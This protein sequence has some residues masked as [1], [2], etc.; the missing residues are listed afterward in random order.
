MDKVSKEQAT[1]E[2]TAWLDF[3]KVAEKRR[4][5]LPHVIDAITDDIYAG[6]LSV[7]TQDFTI[8]QTLKFPIGDGGTTKQITYK[9]RITGAA[10]QEAMAGVLFTDEYGKTWARISASTGVSKNIINKIS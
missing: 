8:T 2:F 1:S 5:S 10:L 9:P 6:H 3:K 7:N 4:E